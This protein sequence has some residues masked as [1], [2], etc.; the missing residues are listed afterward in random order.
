MK[1]RSKK[2]EFEHFSKFSNEWWS[3]NGK[4]KILHSIKPLRMSYIMES[5]GSKNKK[6]LNILDLGCGGGLVCES[7]AKLGCK[8]TGIDFVKDNIK[9]PV[10]A[11]TM[12][13]K[14]LDVKLN[15][16][17]NEKLF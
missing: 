14:N 13:Q 1:V 15:L 4:Y 9:P 11:I 3:E 10:V 6:K 7:L 16:L 12:S 5:I 8:V 2:L 17:K